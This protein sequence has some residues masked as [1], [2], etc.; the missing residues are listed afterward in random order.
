[1]RIH[2]CVSNSTV[3]HYLGKWNVLNFN[4]SNPVWPSRGAERVLWS[5]NMSGSMFLLLPLRPLSLPTC[6]PSCRIFKAVI[7]SDLCIPGTLPP[8]P[9]GWP[10]P[11]P[12]R[13]SLEFWHVHFP[14]SLF[15]LILFVCFYF[16][17]GMGNV[18]IAPHFYF[19]RNTKHRKAYFIPKC[20]GYLKDPFRVF[21]F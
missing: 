12:F 20:R 17:E 2:N 7:Q 11:H 6:L 19:S 16:F 15:F 14:C 10:H 4:E 8:H 13:K 3:W 21:S 5:G 9:I 1:M 18:Q